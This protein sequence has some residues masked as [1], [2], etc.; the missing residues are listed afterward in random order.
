LSGA[1]HPAYTG[2]RDIR[3]PSSIIEHRQS[4]ESTAK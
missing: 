3:M 1:V 2:V 4:N